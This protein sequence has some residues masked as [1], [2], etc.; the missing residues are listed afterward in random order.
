MLKHIRLPIRGII[1]LKDILSRP[2]IREKMIA[3]D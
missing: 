2:N 3:A 1:R